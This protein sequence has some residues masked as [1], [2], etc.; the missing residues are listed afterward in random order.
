MSPQDLCLALPQ[1]TL[2]GA[3]RE[4]EVGREPLTVNRLEKASVYLVDWSRSRG[5]DASDGG[6]PGCSQSPLPPPLPPLPGLAQVQPLTI[7]CLAVTVQGEAFMAGTGVGAWRADAHLLT[8]VV[9][10]GTQV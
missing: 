7:A 3:M 8:I 4:S 5:H 10:C 1:H 6:L 2:P 9:P